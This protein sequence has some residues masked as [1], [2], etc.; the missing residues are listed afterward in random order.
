MAQELRNDEEPE[1][2]DEPQPGAPASDLLR[3]ALGLDPFV[4]LTQRRVLFL[5]GALEENVADE[6]VAQMLL[7]DEPEEPA[8]I[9][10]VIDSPGGLMSGMFA[11]HDTMRLVR[12]PVDT[13]CVGMAASAAAFLLCTPT[14]RRRIT[15]NASVMIHQPSGGTRGTSADI[16]TQARQ[17][18]ENRRRMERL[19]AE[20]TGQPLERL[21]ADMARDHW[22]H[23][24]DAVAYGLVDEV[25]RGP[26]AVGTAG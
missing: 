20:R 9:T 6:L 10:L 13:L 22:L 8:P 23:A 19:M 16:Q 15:P 4:R 5:R 1:H 21:Q 7:L 14:G 12:A 2:E 3:R 17:M 11:L 26:V 18:V 25:V 24:D